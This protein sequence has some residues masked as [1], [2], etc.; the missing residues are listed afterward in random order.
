NQLALG[1]TGALDI[2]KDR[3]SVEI[4]PAVIYHQVLATD[5]IYR[6][7]RWRAGASAIHDRPSQENPFTSE[8]TRPVY[9][10]ATLGTVF[11]DVLL[12]SSWM[13]TIQHM[14]VSGGEIREEGKWASDDRASITSRYP[15][16]E[17]TEVGL[18]WNRPTTRS[19]KLKVKT[20]YMWSDK[21]AF[22]LW[23]LEGRLDLNTD[24][25][26]QSELHMVEARPLDS[27]NRNDIAEFRN[28]DRLAV[29]V[30]YAF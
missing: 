7:K 10:S 15:Y 6:G 9:S 16:Q 13:A 24:W 3:G 29:G 19:R 28:N 25:S 20:S 22:Q 14:G 1:Y 30:G 8:W 21:N 4:Q 2:P 11:V 17:A 27:A 12:A 26:L 5:L 18:E 23:R